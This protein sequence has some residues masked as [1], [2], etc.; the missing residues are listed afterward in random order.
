MRYQYIKDTIYARIAGTAIHLSFNKDRGDSSQITYKKY[1]VWGLKSLVKALIEDIY[2]IFYEHL[3]S[4][5]ELIDPEAEL[6]RPLNILCE[7][8]S[9]PYKKVDRFIEERKKPSQIWDT[10]DNEL[11]TMFM[12]NAFF[13]AFEENLIDNYNATIGFAKL[14]TL[15][16]KR[17]HF[18][19]NPIDFGRGDFGFIFRARGYSNFFSKEI[20]NNGFNNTVKRLNKLLY[21]EYIETFIEKS[22]K[23]IQKNKLSSNKYDNLSEEKKYVIEMLQKGN[24]D[25]KLEAISLI[26]ENRIYDAL[27][28]L[29]YLLSSKDERVM[30]AAFETIVFLKGL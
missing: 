21:Q 6:I 26:T 3:P 22:G 16:K 27:D 7:R 13:E 11:Q 2:N 5:E 1:R 24:S 4:E 10:L 28:E 18:R 12:I 29:E 14:I 30:N 20:Y 17:T 25:E 15:K 9:I 19:L 23:N 8:Y